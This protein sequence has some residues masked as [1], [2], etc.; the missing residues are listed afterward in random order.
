MKRAFEA[1]P[2]SVPPT[3]E[4]PISTDRML[5]VG[6]GITVS[7]EIKSCDCL[8]VEG[9]VRADVSCRELR[10]ALGGLFVGTAAV[11]SAEIVGRFEG[12]LNVAEHLVIRANGKVSA[13]VRY[14]QI[15]IERGGQI[16]G[17]IDTGGANAAGNPAVRGQRLSA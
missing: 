7:G 8:V 9:N 4:K 6:Q 17:D 10:I 1:P 15:E 12:E 11:A 14:Q 3:P 2:S 13:K 5:V 16:S